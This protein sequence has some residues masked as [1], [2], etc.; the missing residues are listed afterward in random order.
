MARPV[1]TSGGKMDVEEVV[2]A[3][4]AVDDVDSTVVG[5]TSP[6]A[7]VTEDDS[8][9]LIDVSDWVDSCTVVVLGEPGRG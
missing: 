1:L 8:S 5:E 2:V 7:V 9:P 6:V 3:C 4:E